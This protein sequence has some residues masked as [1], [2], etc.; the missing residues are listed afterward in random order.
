M[1]SVYTKRYLPL[2]IVWIIFIIFSINYFT[3]EFQIIYNEISSWGTLI[4]LFLIF[5]ATLGYLI[6]SV[7]QINNSLGDGGDKENVILHVYEIVIF[8]SILTVFFVT[9]IDSEQFSWI[10]SYLYIPGEAVAWGFLPAYLSA[11]IYRTWRIRSPETFVLV[12]CFILVMIKGAPISGSLPIII[13]PG[14]WLTSVMEKGPFRVLQMGAGIGI[15]I[16]IIRGL[17]GR[18]VGYE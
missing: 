13:K 8:L 3:G 17:R 18:L 1:S 11:A 9:S 6:R 16:M 15:M 12:I 10:E 14:L 5:T 7:F 4:S 2:T